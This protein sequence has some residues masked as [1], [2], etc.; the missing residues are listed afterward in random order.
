MVMNLIKA[1]LTYMKTGY[2]LK[3]K[4][5]IMLSQILYLSYPFVRFC[6]LCF[7]RSIF[8][9]DSLIKHYKCKNEFG[10][11]LCPG[12]KYGALFTKEF[13]PSVKEVLH[14]FHSGTFVDI[15]A[16]IGLYT[17]MMSKILGKRGK[18]IGI[19]PDPDLFSVLKENV[20]IN[21]CSNVEL[22]NVAAW[23]TDSKLKLYKAQFGASFLHNSVMKK[24]SE[25]YDEVDAVP[26]DKIVKQEKVD[27]IK[28]DVEGAE[29]EVFK[30][31]KRIFFNNPSLQIVFESREGS[32]SFEM[33]KSLDFN[34]NRLADGNYYAIKKNSKDEPSSKTN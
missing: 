28:I 1:Y 10:I 26:L 24:I 14:Q 5:L 17:I 30:G 33:L 32:P 4:F 11:F 21:N 8:S 9:P 23:S 29:V 2:S 25:K 16:N 31:S 12:G 7:G 13:E 22:F 27:L 15:G 6:Y 19:E 3:D 20:R 18:V 34:V